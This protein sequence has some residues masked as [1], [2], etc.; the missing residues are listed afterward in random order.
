M[1]SSA[2]KPDVFFGCRNMT[3]STFGV[4]GEWHYVCLHS[5]QTHAL[6]RKYHYIASTHWITYWRA[7]TIL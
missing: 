6:A 1:E 7:G 3:G 2:C 4:R 5:L